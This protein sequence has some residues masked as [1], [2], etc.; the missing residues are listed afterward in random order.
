M[1]IEFRYGSTWQVLGSDNFDSLVGARPTG[2]SSGVGARDPAAWAYLSPILEE[3]GGWAS[4][5][6]PPPRGRNHGD[7][8]INAPENEPGWFAL[9]PGRSTSTFLARTARQHS[10]PKL[11]DLYGEE[12][13]ENLFKSGIPRNQ[14]RRGDPRLLLRR[15]IWPSS[16]RAK[17][18]TSGFPTIRPIPF[19]RPWDLGLD[20]LTVVSSVPAHRPRGALDR[21]LGAATESLIDSARDISTS[22]TSTASTRPHDIDVR[23]KT[24]AMTRKQSLKTSDCDP[25]VLALSDWSGRARQCAAQHAQDLGVRCRERVQEGPGGTAPLS[26]RMGREGKDAA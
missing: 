24:T 1:L 25:S 19:I 4:C 11:I 2:S 6:S 15:K 20:D 14:F 5:S 13:G 12:D 17:G 7:L 8:F 10:R 9:Q 3:N 22:A 16:I 26:F 21:L 23:E 18:S